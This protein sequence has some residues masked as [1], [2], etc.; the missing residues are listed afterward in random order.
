M[1]PAGSGD[2]PETADAQLL[3]HNWGCAME[4]DLV[5]AVGLAGTALTAEVVRR[6]GAAGNYKP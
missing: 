2:V 4:I 6:L 5:T 1:N 3:L